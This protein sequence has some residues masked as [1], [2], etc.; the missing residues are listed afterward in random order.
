[1]LTTTTY[2]TWL[3]GDVRGY[4]DDGVVLPHDPAVLERALGRLKGEPVYLTDREQSAAFA[5]LESARDE[6]GYALLA[7]SVESWHVHALVDHGYDAVADVAGRLKTR[8]RQAVVATRGR[9]ATAAGRLWTA[10][11]D[12]RYCFTADAVVGRA[13]YIGRHR[14]ARVVRARPTTVDMPGPQRL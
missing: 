6:F 3:P 12:A 4:V 10:G 11:Y 1:M 9:G 8:M 14:G 2:G 7:A 13:G 5:A